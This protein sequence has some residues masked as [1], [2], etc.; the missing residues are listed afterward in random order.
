MS[1]C[2]I[3][4]LRDE[5]YD[6]SQYQESRIADAILDATEEIETYTRRFFEPRNLTFRVTW[7]GRGA[8]LLQDPIIRI[9]ELRVILPDGTLDADPLDPADYIV[10]NRHVFEGLLE[11]DDRESPKILLPESFPRIIDGVIQ[12]QSLALRTTTRP[13]LNLRVIGRFGYTNPSADVGRTVTADGTDAITAPDILKAAKAAF[14]EADVAANVVISGAANSANNGTFEILEVL[15]S[16]Q[17][18]LNT[19]ALVTEGSGFAIALEAYPQSGVTPRAIRRACILLAAERLPK[20]AE[21][22]PVD[23]AMQ[24][25]RVSRMAVR[26]QA[27]TF[28]ADRRL[29]SGQA[30]TM[31]SEATR[32]LKPYR[33][34]PRMR[35]V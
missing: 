16:D 33:R 7:N 11:D 10:F 14:T 30:A 20:L 8:L 5:G 21:I 15:A 26:D 27:I 28:V 35:A 31:N 24:Q 23:Q 17:V 13:A 2:T 1:Y 18:R 6:C 9:D 19:T 22:D 12:S 3:D 25:G 4:D 34:P 32:L 29:E